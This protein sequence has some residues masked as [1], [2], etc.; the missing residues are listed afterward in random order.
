MPASPLR[1]RHYK[2]QL[3]TLNSFQEAQEQAIDAYAS[4]LNQPG[5][6]AASKPL[7]KPLTVPKTTIYTTVVDYLRWTASRARSND[8]DEV[9]AKNVHD[10]M[11][12]HILPYMQQ[13]KIDRLDD[14]KL[15]CF[16]NYKVWRGGEIT[17]HTLRNELS[18]IRN[19]L[20]Y[21]N[22]QELLPLRLAARINELEASTSQGCGSTG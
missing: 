1:G 20:G 19:W 16:D 9:Y 15:G 10:Y 4:L 6:E 12:N 2:T 8:L 5:F 18:H 13:H 22:R 3:L 11:T 7:E 21:L 17:K 14:L